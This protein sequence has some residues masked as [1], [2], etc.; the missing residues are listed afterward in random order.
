MNE[1]LQNAMDTV[2]ET[3]RGYEIK[4]ND[5][6]AFYVWDINVGH[7][8]YGNTLEEIKSDIDNFLDNK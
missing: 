2:I 4:H 1:A 6:D 8:F 7:D 5:E 3:Y